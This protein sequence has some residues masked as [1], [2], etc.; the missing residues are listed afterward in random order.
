MGSPAARSTRAESTARVGVEE[1]EAPAALSALH[2]LSAMRNNAEEAGGCLFLVC[3]ERR[4]AWQT[5]TYKQ[6]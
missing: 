4:T 1:V 6:N 5:Q 3:R 2:T